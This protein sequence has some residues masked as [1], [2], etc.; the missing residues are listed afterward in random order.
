MSYKTINLDD[1]PRASHFQLFRNMQRP[2]LGLTAMVEVSGLMERL[3]PAGYPVF[4]TALFAVISS[5]NSIAEFRTRFREGEVIEHDAV[6]A[7]FTVPIAG[8]RFGFAEVEYVADWHEFN[9]SCLAEIDRAKNQTSL[10]DKVAT[11]DDWIYLSC[12]PWLSF[13]SM[14]NPFAD[15]DDCIPRITWGKITRSGDK[16]QMPVCVEAHHSLIDGYHIAMLFENIQKTI[17][18]MGQ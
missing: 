8:D 16:W 18:Q 17:E 12:L 13:T 9:R 11:R 6:H 2:H 7:S 4:N 5:A 14:S 3:K 10:I 1:W 15:A